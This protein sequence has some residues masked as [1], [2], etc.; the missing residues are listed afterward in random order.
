MIWGIWSV[1]YMVRVY[2]VLLLLVVPIVVQPRLAADSGA[3]LGQRALTVKMESEKADELEKSPPIHGDIV[4]FKN[5]KKLAG[6]QVIK[7]TLV[8]IEVVP[9]PGVES[10]ILPRSLIKSIEYDN[11]TSADG[12][13]LLNTIGDDYDKEVMEG[14][15][16]SP[17]LHTKMTRPLYTEKRSYE[18]VDFKELL[19][20]LA[21]K[22][23]LTIVF[24]TALEALPPEKRKWTVELEP[25]TSLLHLLQTDFARSFPDMEWVYQ[26]DKIGVY[27]RKNVPRE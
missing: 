20:E 6:V 10:L 23:D 5:G 16:I 27:V 2:L 21:E 17:E 3:T 18:G 7:E 9:A 22:C 25:E 4:H 11:I 15:E 19:T 13:W 12:N 26:F 8:S 14:K 24:G 1:D